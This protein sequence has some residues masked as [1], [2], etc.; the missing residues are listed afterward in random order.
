MSVEASRP[1]RHLA[2]ARRGVD[3]WVGTHATPSEGR[4]GSPVA[5]ALG[6]H[7]PAGGSR[8]H[9]QSRDAGRSKPQS[10][11][12]FL[13]VTRSRHHGADR[14]DFDPIYGSSS[15]SPATRAVV[16]PARTERQSSNDSGA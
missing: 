11:R 13:T 12:G 16:N 15:V 4:A 7:A 5:P 14:R 2:T 6:T 3:V 10:S 1:G 9:F 8:P